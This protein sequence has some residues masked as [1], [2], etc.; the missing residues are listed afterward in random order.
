[1]STATACGVGLSSAGA[2]HWNATH[3]EAFHAMDETD[4]DY[5]WVAVHTDTYWAHDEAATDER[6]RMVARTLAA[7]A[8]LFMFFGPL[9]RLCREDACEGSSST[10]LGGGTDAGCVRPADHG[11]TYDYA[12]SVCR[13]TD[14]YCE[15][16]GFEKQAYEGAPGVPECRQ[17]EA[18]RWAELFLGTTLRAGTRAS[19]RASRT[20]SSRATPARRRCARSTCSFPPTSTSAPRETCLT[21]E[22]TCTDSSSRATRRAPRASIR[23]GEQV[24]QTALATAQTVTE[25]TSDALVDDA[26]DLNTEVFDLLFDGGGGS[27][28]ADRGEA[29]RSVLGRRRLQD[30]DHQRE[31]APL[32]RRPVSAGRRGSAM[33][34]RWALHALQ[35][36]QG[37]AAPLPPRRVPGRTSGGALPLGRRLSDLFRRPAVLRRRRV[38]ERRRERPV[39]RTPR[40][41]TGL[42]LHERALRARRRGRRVRTRRP[43]PP[44]PGRNGKRVCHGGRCRRGAQGSACGGDHDCQFVPGTTRARCHNG[45]CERGGVGSAC[46]GN[47]ANCRAGLVCPLDTCETPEAAATRRAELAQTMQSAGNSFANLFR[48]RFKL[49]TS[50]TTAPG[51]LHGTSYVDL[52]RHGRTGLESGLGSSDCVRAGRRRGVVAVGHRNSRHPNP[53]YRNTCFAYTDASIAPTLRAW[54]KHGGGRADRVHTTSILR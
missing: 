36:R 42:F 54:A 33:P 38:P 29:G 23:L 8:T 27:A 46:A 32:P 14:R 4:P 26:A 2:D 39:R 43:L 51:F 6:P 20:P 53:T 30:R 21:A 12:R 52:T 48:K 9:V 34:S 17:D 40:V 19:S 22:T 11:V 1:M 47:D 28:H 15:A 44:V 10:S 16:F 5:P 41:Q 37:D 50:P 24:A 25:T 7:P 3:A 18:A 13:Y 45:T 35:V 49:P 31:R